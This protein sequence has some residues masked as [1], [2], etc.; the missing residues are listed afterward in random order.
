MKY[1]YAPLEGITF[2]VL[3]EVHFSLFPGVDSYY[4]PFLAPDREGTFKPGFLQS[5]LPDASKGIPLVPQL[6]CNHAGSFLITAEKLRDIGYNEINLN[7]GCPS[8]TVFSKHKGAGMLADLNSLDAFLEEVFSAASKTGLKV[9]VKTRMGVSSTA[10]FPKILEIY[11]R[12]PLSLLI[13]HARDKAGQYHSVPDVSGF[14]EGARLSKNPVCYNGEI[15]SKADL[16]ALLSAVPELSSVMIGRGAVANPALFR[17]L[18]GGKDLTA[19]EMK[20]YHDEILRRTLEEGLAPNFTVQRMKG[21]WYYMIAMYPGSEKAFKT[22]NK[23]HTLDDYRWAADSVL[24]GDRF[25]SRSAFAG[26]RI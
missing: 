11:N 16:D 10:E 22:L 25:S 3:R 1:L 6:L 21:L 26:T 13:I 4:S 12:Y 17:G 19:A 23:A 2:P 24:Q 20:N 18:C 14:A 15:F 5:R 8:P 7:A 9:S